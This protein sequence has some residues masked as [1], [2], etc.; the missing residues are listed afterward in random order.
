MFDS[1]SEKV[2]N[3]LHIRKFALKSRIGERRIWLRE[4]FDRERSARVRE[5]EQGR[6]NKAPLVNVTVEE[7]ADDG[8]GE[9]GL[10]MASDVERVRDGAFF[11][12]ELCRTRQWVDVD[13]GPRGSRE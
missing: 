6:R 1:V 7:V 9:R 10:E 4:S 2:G 8:F 11:G 5:S 13:T 3:W 12:F